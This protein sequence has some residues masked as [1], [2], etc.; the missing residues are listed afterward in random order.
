MRVPTQDRDLLGGG[1]V[2]DAGGLIDRRCDYARSIGAEGGVHHRVF[3]SLQDCD[4]LAGGGIPD[5]RG[6]VGR[7]GDDARAVGTERGKHDSALMPR[8][9]QPQVRVP[10]RGGQRR[11]RQRALRRV[12]QAKLGACGM[13]C[14][15]QTGVEVAGQPLAGRELGQEIDMPAI[16][17]DHTTTPTP[18]NPLRKRFRR[19]TTIRKIPCFA[20][21]PPR[22]S[23]LRRSTL[24]SQ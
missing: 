3:M 14:Q 22:V 9:R 17:L 5:A 2:P 24:G 19:R 18:L 15:P 4:L 10:D 12:A 11:L 23:A 20:L 8:E 16:E 1:G 13:D 6:V 21:L 7:R